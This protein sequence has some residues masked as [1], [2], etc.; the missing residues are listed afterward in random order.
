MLKQNTDQTIK[1]FYMIYIIVAVS[2]TILI[3]ITLLIDLCVVL[4]ST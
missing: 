2:H 3:S 4:L 1:F